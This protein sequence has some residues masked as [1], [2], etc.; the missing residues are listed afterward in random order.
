MVNR[1]NKIEG[2]AKQ[3]QAQQSAHTPCMSCN[4]TAPPARVLQPVYFT[5][6]HLQQKQAHSGASTTLYHHGGQQGSSTRATV[7]QK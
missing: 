5:V 4:G 3:Q 1:S 7:Q 6:V 2:V